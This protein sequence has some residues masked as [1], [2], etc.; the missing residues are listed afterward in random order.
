M[1]NGKLIACQK[2]TEPTTKPVQRNAIDKAYIAI[3]SVL[4]H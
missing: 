3:A 2:E 4:Q 1:E